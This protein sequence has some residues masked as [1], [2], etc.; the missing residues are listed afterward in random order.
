MAR[1]GLD[2]E[3]ADAILE[4]HLYALGRKDILQVR[5]ELADKTAQR[6]K[7]EAVLA[8]EAALW[9]FIRREMVES[10]KALQDGRRTRILE[11]GVPELSFQEVDLIVEEQ[12]QVVITR[13]GWIR[14]ATMGTDTS[15]LRLRQDDEIT[16]VIP[17][18]NLASVLFFT[19]LG[20]VY[21]MRVNDIPLTKAAGYGDPVQKF[22]KFADGERVVAAFTFDSRDTSGISLMEGCEVPPLHG[23]AVASDGKGLRFSFEGFVEP[24]T[25]KGRRF[26]KLAEHGHI[27]SVEAVNG[28][29]TAIVVSKGG[30]AL[31]FPV[32]EASFLSGV[33]R[34]V[35]FINLDE[36]DTVLDMVTVDSRNRGI[37]VVREEGGKV[38]EVVPK[39][40]KTVARGGKG[41][42]LSK[43][44]RLRVE[45][46]HLNL[47]YSG[48]LPD[49]G[50]ENG[51]VN[52][53][54]GVDQPDA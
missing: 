15:K 44:G 8:S 13:D 51:T 48:T 31:L 7:L 26:A 25:K 21:T 16:D 37:S 20:T 22:F 46:R 50:A 32:G 18:T 14:R 34:G 5:E 3:Q 41:H 47:D 52:G 49:G 24:S 53:T 19:D 9:R 28:S 39:Y 10:H 54:G 12:T 11:D 45:N 35:C 43:R 29:E 6:A 36:G 38:F 2:R 33:G 30:R 40:Y 17:T 1:F 42:S 23:I 27:V 4:L